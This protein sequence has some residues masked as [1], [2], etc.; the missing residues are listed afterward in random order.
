VIIIIL[1]P[2]VK[3]K[4]Y[5]FWIAAILEIVLASAAFR[6]RR[7]SQSWFFIMVMFS[8]CAPI[9][10]AANISKFVPIGISPL[11]FLA[12]ALV[13][14]TFSKSK[15]SLKNSNYSITLPQDFA[16]RAFL[17]SDLTLGLKLEDHHVYKNKQ[18][19]TL[20]LYYENEQG[21]WLWIYESNGKINRDK[22]KLK[23]QIIQKI[24]NGVPVIIM[25]EIRNSDRFR[26]NLP[27]SYLEA[28]WSR[29]GVNF[30]IRTDMISPVEAEKIIASMIK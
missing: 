1:S 13:I 27:Y 14:L 23:T 29:N 4:D 6:I 3:V 12:T 11:I 9:V 17:P 22:I 26:Q 10:L 2:F 30:N 21:A 25:Q 16:F 19:T 24:I 5:L 28:T 7:Y 15:R 20:E 18:K 8:I